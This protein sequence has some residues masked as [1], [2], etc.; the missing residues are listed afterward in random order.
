MSL[1]FTHTVCLISDVLFR[2]RRKVSE[3]FYFDMNTE[4]VKKMM[5]GHIE[6]ADISTY[7]RYLP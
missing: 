6:Y 5:A 3:N 2:E 1:I 7:A 4:S